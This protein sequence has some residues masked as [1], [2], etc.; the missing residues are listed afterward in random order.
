MYKNILVNVSHTDGREERLKWAVHFA[1]LHKAQLNVIYVTNPAK[2][3][4]EVKGRAA[5]T[6]YIAEVAEMARERSCETEAEIKEL[7]KKEKLD[8]TWEVID[9]DPIP[10]ILHLS[11]LT[12]LSIFSQHDPEHAE[13]RFLQHSPETVLLKTGSTV[14]LLPYNKPVQTIGKRIM[15]AW[16]NSRGAIRAARSAAHLFDSSKEIMVF[17]GKK[18]DPDS[19]HAAEIITY[20]KTH[21]NGIDPRDLGPIPTKGNAGK[22]ILEQAQENNADLIVMGAYGH[23]RMRELVLGGATHYVLNHTDR[24]ILMCH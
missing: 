9:G 21:F 7:C 2:V 6:A 1:K 8:F 3:P 16:K 18:S 20:L 14:L 17:T 13:N 19:T 22:T 11:N 24:P 23:S 5:S 4:D 10:R 15:V 12:D